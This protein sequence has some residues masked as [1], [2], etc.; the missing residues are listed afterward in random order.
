MVDS[1][2]NR[3]YVISLPTADTLAILEDHSKEICLANR[4]PKPWLLHH[5]YV[6]ICSYPSKNTVNESIQMDSWLKSY[7]KY[8]G[9]VGMAQIVSCTKLGFNMDYSAG[10]KIEIGTT[11]FL[12]APFPLKYRRSLGYLPTETRDQFLKFTGYEVW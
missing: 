2:K 3:F 6:G 4:L 11:N 9:I 8:E 12:P 5:S 10:Y 1:F 7:L